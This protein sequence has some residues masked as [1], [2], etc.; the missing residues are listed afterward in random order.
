MTG[1]LRETDLYPPIK[2]FLERQGFEVKAEIGAAD[3]V[4]LKGG[5]MVVIELKRGFSLALFHQ[6]I[7]RLA[8]ADVV[9][10]AVARGQGRAWARALRDNTKL[11]RRLGLGVLTVALE[12]A[13][14]E[15]HCDPGPYAP[16]K[17]ARRK[18]AMLTEFHA[19]SGDPNL[20][21]AAGARVTAYRQ[22]ATL[23]AEFLAL[24]GT[25][26]GVEVARATG[27]ARATAIMRDNHYGWFEKVALG[28]Y[29]L[30]AEGQTQMQAVAVAD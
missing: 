2:A 5:E 3:V 13:R 1:P 25:A 9:Y 4:G 12:T 14:V 10:V 29:R 19:R 28:T 7:A 24:A 26:K 17:Q 22:D 6:A 8:V 27:V 30:S 20:G 23:C 16:R 11:A 15:V 18:A 21:G